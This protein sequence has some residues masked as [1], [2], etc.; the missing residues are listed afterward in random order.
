M[1]LYIFYVYVKYGCFK[2]MSIF[3]LVPGIC[4]KPSW[5]GL[6]PEIL[7]MSGL[8][9]CGRQLLDDCVRPTV[10]LLSLF[11]L[12]TVV[13]TPTSSIHARPQQGHFVTGYILS[14]RF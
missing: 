8:A 4:N 1:F 7:P 6:K 12:E 5:S 11:D 13:I 14:W 3:K 9:I 2:I 10:D